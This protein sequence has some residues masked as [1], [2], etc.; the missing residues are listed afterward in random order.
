[1]NNS[2]VMAVAYQTKHPPTYALTHFFYLFPHRLFPN[3]FYPTSSPPLLISI[4][5]SK[6]NNN[7]L[8]HIPYPISLII[9]PTPFPILTSFTRYCL[10]GETVNL[11]S[12]MESTGEAGRLH[13][14][15]A[16]AEVLMKG[17]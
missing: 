4:P 7:P 3:L 6:P 11:A 14:S 2:M 16:V 1:M 15:E 17:Q 10:F 8:S 5:Y 13:C 12:R 9:V